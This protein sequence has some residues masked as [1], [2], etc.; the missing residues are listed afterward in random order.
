M[1]IDLACTLFRLPLLLM[2]P[3]NDIKLQGPHPSKIQQ[4]SKG[5]AVSDSHIVFMIRRFM[6]E[7]SRH[8]MVHAL[9]NSGSAF[10]Q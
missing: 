6:K 8:R 10:K 3:S 5:D 7:L 4:P 1:N 2:S 9:S